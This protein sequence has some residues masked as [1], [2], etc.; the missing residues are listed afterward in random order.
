MTPMIPIL[1]AFVLQAPPAAPRT[2]RPATIVDAMVAMLAER[3]QDE[4]VGKRLAADLAARRDRG[5]YAALTTPDAL[6]QRWTADLQAISHDKHLRVFAEPRQPPQA[7][8]G[9]IGKVDVLDG[10]VGLIE[11]T[12]FG[13]PLELFEPAL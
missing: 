4:A 12:S 8:G 2:V 9:G 10:N 11:V 3:Y 1:L 7:P 13:Q 6:A 5:E